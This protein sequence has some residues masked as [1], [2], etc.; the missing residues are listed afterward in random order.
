M[1]SKPHTSR[2]RELLADV[3]R[4]LLTVNEDTDLICDV[5]GAGCKG[6]CI[7]RSI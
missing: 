5:N 6:T 4:L 2:E 3:Q 7:K 1:L